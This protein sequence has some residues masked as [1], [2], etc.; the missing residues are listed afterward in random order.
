MEETSLLVGEIHSPPPFGDWFA[1]LEELPRHAASAM[2][3]G[4]GL[5]HKHW[6]IK[7]E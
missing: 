2:S 5:G 4:T 1:Q 3:A 6:K 7:S